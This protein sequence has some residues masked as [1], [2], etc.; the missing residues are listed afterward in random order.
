[1]NVIDMY[2]YYFFDKPCRKLNKDECRFVLCDKS[3]VYRRIVADETIRR[4]VNDYPDVLEYMLY[5]VSGETGLPAH[6]TCCMYLYRKTGAQEHG[7]EKEEDTYLET[8]HVCNAIPIMIGSRLEKKVMSRL[9]SML[10]IGVSS[11]YDEHY[12][13]T[14]YSGSFMIN[15][16]LYYSLFR[17]S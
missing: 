12:L 9:A 6:Y 3:I 10:G 15:G 5:N 7:G 1:M 16:T 13:H 2:D 14:V 4:N 11:V 8:G 17:E